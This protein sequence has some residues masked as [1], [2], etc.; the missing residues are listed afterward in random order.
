MN[1]CWKWLTAPRWS[2][3]VAGVGIGVLSWLTFGLMGRGL[4]TSTTF[5]RVAGTLEGAVAREHVEANPYY[6]NL[7]VDRPI[8]EWQFALVIFL[9]LGAFI[10]SKLSGSTFVEHVPKLWAWR[11]GPSR[12]LRYAAAF[13]GGLVLVFGARMAG[14]CTSGH[15]ITGGLQLAVSSWSFLIAMFIS[16]IAVTFLI[17]GREGRAHV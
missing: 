16:G 3:Y 6:A 2:P 14:G 11:F 5:V 12:T 17:F 13:L 9:L 10:A 1:I 8:V 15:A 7:L 4:G